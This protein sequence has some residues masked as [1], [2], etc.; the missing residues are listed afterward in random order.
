MGLISGALIGYIIA[1]VALFDNNWAYWGV[2]GGCALSFFLFSCY[3]QNNIRI[4]I[5]SLIGSFSIT[6]GIGTYL[7]GFPNEIEL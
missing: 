5:T 3:C 4:F 1:T 7:G 6:R 2:I